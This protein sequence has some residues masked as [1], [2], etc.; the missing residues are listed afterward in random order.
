MVAN[1]D[2]QY[3]ETVHPSLRHNH[4]LE[5]PQDR[6]ATASSSDARNKE[7]SRQPHLFVILFCDAASMM[8]S[9]NCLHWRTYKRG[10]KKEWPL[11][12]Y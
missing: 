7:H 1:E 5:D 2:K 12:F 11:N 6:F 10:E 3:I 9:M 4:P 8:A